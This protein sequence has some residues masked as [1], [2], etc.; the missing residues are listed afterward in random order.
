MTALGDEIVHLPKG[1]FV[2]LH[3]PPNPTVSETSTPLNDGMEEGQGVLF[4]Y[5]KKL[6]P[7][8]STTSRAHGIGREKYG[9]TLNVDDK[10]GSNMVVPAQRIQSDAYVARSP[11][12]TSTVRFICWG[13]VPTRAGTVEEM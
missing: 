13:G 1:W 5:D 7:N 8:S 10:D 3:R 9:H 4:V 11:D 6:S 2:A 12:D